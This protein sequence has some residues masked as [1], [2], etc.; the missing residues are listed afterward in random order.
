MET[1]KRQ[2]LEKVER[3]RVL[4]EIMKEPRLNFYL[5][6]NE[7]NSSASKDL[8]K[9]AVPAPSPASASSFFSE[10]NHHPSPNTL[11]SK[12][13]L[14]SFSSRSSDSY[15]GFAPLQS[16]AVSSSSRTTTNAYTSGNNSERSRTHAEGGVYTPQGESSFSA[17]TTHNAARSLSPNNPLPLS[18]SSS[19]SAERWNKNELSSMAMLITRKK[20]EK[21]KPEEKKFEEKDWDALDADLQMPPESLVSALVAFSS[22]VEALRGLSWRRCKDLVEKLSRLLTAWTPPHTARSTTSSSSPEGEGG[23]TASSRPGKAEGKKKEAEQDTDDEEDVSSTEREKKAKRL[24]ETER[25][26][27]GNLVKALLCERFEHHLHHQLF[28]LKIK[29][30]RLLKK[31][32]K[33]HFLAEDLDLTLTYQETETVRH[34]TFTSFPFSEPPSTDMLANTRGIPQER[35]LWFHTPSYTCKYPHVKRRAYT[36]HVYGG[37][38]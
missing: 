29:E 9:P 26:R 17:D 3:E 27:K 23:K 20:R 22:S 11:F 19:S 5:K 15:K 8:S 1:R 34:P 4:Q 30:F 18:F 24:I 12:N 25:D 33:S 6:E 14:S 13:T 21:K 32:K 2:Y 7:A 28:D 31:K 38:L 37:H 10:M 35:A 16:E 36:A